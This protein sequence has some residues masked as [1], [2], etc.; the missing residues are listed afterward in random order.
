[1]TPLFGMT[2]S[3]LTTVAAEVGLPRFAAKQMADWLYKKNVS[4]TDQMTNLPKAARATLAE[5]YNVG[6]TEPAN[7]AQSIDGTKKYLFGTPGRQIETAYIPEADRA[8]LCVS[9]QVGCKMS[10][11][12]CMTGRQG[13]SSNLTTTE[14]L[15][16]VASIPEHDKLTNIVYMGMGEPMDNLANVLKSIEILTSDWGY[17]WSPRRITVSTIGVMPATVQFLQSCQAHLAISLH[18]AIPEQRLSIM[19]TEK[20]FPITQTIT[21]LKQFDWTGQRRLSFEYTMFNGIN[22]TQQHVAAISKLLSGMRCRINII[23]FNAIPD[24][25][26][27]GSPRNTMEHFRD[28]LNQRGFTATIRNSRG[29]DIFAACGLLSTM[30]KNKINLIQK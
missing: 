26:L 28:Q 9:S 12:F 20:A 14:I 16:Q 3:E 23:S 18:N 15:N 21:A 2:L 19:P 10:C 29:S 25:T 7:V 8:T 24:S 5:K 27:Q 1:M 4:S 17:A 22:D 30:E 6:R 11:L 13:F